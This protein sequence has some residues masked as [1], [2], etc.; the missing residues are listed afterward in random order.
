MTGNLLFG[1]ALRLFLVS[2]QSGSTAII[3]HPA[4]P[5]DRPDMPL[6][7]RLD[8][9]QLFLRFS[10][11]QRLR[12]QQGCFGAPSAKPTNFL[13]TH[14]PLAAQQLRTGKTTEVPTGSSIGKNTEGV[15]NTSRL[16]QYPGAL[17]HVLARIFLTAQPDEGT[18]A[19]PESFTCAVQ[20]MVDRCDVEAEMG[21]DY[22][23]NALNAANW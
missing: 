14:A 18:S 3:E 11:C 9:A 23:V 5:T 4:E 17:C 7:W 20:A 2:I 21:P 12:I 10:C 8:I 6:I 16:K 15:W 22:N 19:I 13:V 1:V